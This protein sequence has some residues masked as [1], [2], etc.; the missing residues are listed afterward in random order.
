MDLGNK[1]PFDAKNSNKVQ[2]INSMPLS[3]LTMVMFF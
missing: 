2:F 1:T 3:V